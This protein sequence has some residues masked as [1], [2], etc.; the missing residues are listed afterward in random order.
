M[1]RLN[2]LKKI[3]LYACVLLCA[4]LMFGNAQAQSQKPNIIFILGDDIG[5]KTFSFNGGQSY[6]TPNLDSMV[7]RGMNFTGCHASPLCSPSRMLLLTGKYNFRNYFKWGVMDTNQKS[8]ANV[9]KDAGYTTA[10]FGKWQLD[11]GDVSLHKFGF[12]SYNVW[13]PFAGF[14]P[15]RYKFPVLYTNGET[16]ADSIIGNQ[17]SED[18]MTDSVINFMKRNKSVPFFIYYSM[19]LVHP[20]YQPTPDDSAYAS[21]TSR[22]LSDTSF[23]KSDIEY[24][25]KKIGEIVNKVKQLGIANNTVI[26]YTGDNGTPKD[27]FQ[28]IDDSTEEGGKGLSVEKG[29]QVPLIIDWPKEIKAG[30]VN[31]DLISF[32]DFFPTLAHMANTSLPTDDGTLDGVDFYPRLKGNPGT[33]RQWLFYD[34]DPYPGADTSIRWAETKEYKLYDTSL[35]NSNRAFYNIKKD[36]NEVDSISHNS[37]T[38]DELSIKQELLRVINS[39]VKQG[40]P[41]LSKADLVSLTDSSV[42]AED[43]I[44]TYGESTLK[45]NGMVWSENPDPVYPTS[46]HIS[47]NS[48]LGLFQANIKGLKANSVYYIRAYA[49]NFAGVAYSNEIKFRTLLHAPVALTATSVNNSMLIANWHSV[50]AASKYKLYVSTRPNFVNIKP[51]TVDERFNNGVIPPN[52]WIF[53][54]NI[55][56]NNTA[57][58]QGGPA[59]QFNVGNPQ[60][61]TKQLAGPATQLKFWIKGLNTDSIGHFLVEGFNG[62]KWLTI[63][64]IQ[65]IS[66]DG[67][68]KTFDSSSN[69]PLPPNIIQFRFTYYKGKGTG[70]VAFD[71]VYIKYN[72]ITNSFVNG[73]DGLAVNDTSAIV[74]GLK[75]GTTYYYRVKAISSN[76]TSGNSNTISATTCASADCNQNAIAND[77]MN[78]INV[79]PNPSS[80]DFTLVVS[81]TNS[82]VEID[83]IDV[84]GKTV[85]QTKAF[86]HNNFVFGK[87]FAPGIYFARVTQDGNAKSFKLVKQ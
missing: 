78:N 79:F 68:T 2:S 26:I 22:S 66:K 25:D 34:Y 83:V 32:V 16:I 69:T 56:V 55:V 63:K 46:S 50:N 65:P 45:N 19:L 52:G 54:G 77:M 85:Y 87:N 81:K 14:E 29:L 7:K 49:K 36:P 27:V 4:L 21:W 74:T 8:I 9:L 51:K 73:Y 72:I 35:Y 67:L 37:L 6:N 70:S 33:P 86:N 82:Q 61:I 41:L 80:K 11:G 84:N 1:D 62:L 60:V 23:Y 17:Y 47:Y 38:P 24:M 31:H 76:N 28:Q 58:N 48:G 10:C 18:I 39:Y 43:S 20:P 40:I 44:R 5:L 42:I 71:N 75:A 64:S 13:M 57:H 15:A 30:S 59:L 53:A 12:D 3:M